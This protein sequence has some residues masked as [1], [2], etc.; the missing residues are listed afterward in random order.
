MRRLHLAM[1][2]GSVLGC[3]GGNSSAADTT[4]KT[5]N[6]AVA[7]GSLA[8]NYHAVS[9]NGDSVSLLA[10]R[11]RVVL[12][13]IW[14]TWCHPCRSEIPALQAIHTRYQPRGLELVGVSV[15]NDGADNDI[16]EFMKEFGMSY[17]VWR[18]PEERVSSQF[19]LVGVPA[20][21]LIDQQGILRWRHT[22]PI[23]SDDPSLSA[24]IEHA[25]ERSQ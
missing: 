2:L 15:D 18:D 17:A 20:T 12:V 14:A 13:N 8:P 24:A 4:A 6:G 11:G 5:G 19:L 16:R 25:L 22:G 9:L 1:V 10:M 23:A 7:V 3:G 21:F